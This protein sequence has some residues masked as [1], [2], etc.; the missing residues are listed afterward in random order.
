MY[1]YITKATDG[2]S[3]LMP[4][5]VLPWENLGAAK[6]TDE[7]AL[8]P[9]PPTGLASFFCAKPEAVQTSLQDKPPGGCGGRVL[10]ARDANF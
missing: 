8:I 4:I 2:I 7:K 1:P 9:L 6:K 5:A 10:F 3:T